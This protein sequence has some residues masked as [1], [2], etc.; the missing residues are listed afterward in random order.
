MDV[1]RGRFRI[2]V[3]PSPRRPCKWHDEAPSAPHAINAIVSLVPRFPLHAINAVR[4]TP[5]TR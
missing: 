3:S 5:S 2:G 1:C 4:R